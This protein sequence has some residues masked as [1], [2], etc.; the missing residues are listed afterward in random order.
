M[1]DWTLSEKLEQ[2]GFH[3][4][5]ELQYLY[6][7]LKCEDSKSKEQ[8]IANI[9]YFMDCLRRLVKECPN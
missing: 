8:V 9:H 3:V 4:Q 7:W 6:F 1:R 2:I 5:E